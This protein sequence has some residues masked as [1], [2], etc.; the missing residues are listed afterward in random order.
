MILCWGIAFTCC[1]S[2]IHAA[3]VTAFSALRPGDQLEAV[4][5]TTGCF[6]NLE[7]ELLF[8]RATA[9]H[10]TIVNVDRTRSDDQ[11]TFITNRVMLGSLELTNDDIQGL[12][13]LLA[14][15]RSGPPSCCTT[16]DTITMSQRHEGKVVATAKFTDGSC[17]VFRRKNITSFG[18]L[19][20]R[21]PEPVVPAPSLSR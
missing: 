3:P 12:D 19:V 13:R 18:A 7:Y 14:F 8:K 15:Y 5:N 10:V 17:S 16:V 2:S 21:L 6:H 9:L 1:V 20:A 4:Y 11:R